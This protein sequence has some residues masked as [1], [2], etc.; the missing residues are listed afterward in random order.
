MIFMYQLV[1]AGLMEFTLDPEANFAAF[2][3]AAQIALGAPF[4][5]VATRKGVAAV[6]HGYQCNAPT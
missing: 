1:D 6:K 5:L 2:A 4:V 3:E